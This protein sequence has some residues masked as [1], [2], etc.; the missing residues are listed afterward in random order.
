MML[1]KQRCSICKQETS[2]RFIRL[3]PFAGDKRYSTEAL[4]IC[5]RCEEIVTSMVELL[6][7]TGCES[8]LTVYTERGIL[9]EASV[10]Y[11]TQTQTQEE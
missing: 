6:I 7:L 3:Y 4:R 5:K 2:C 11:G 8:R 1:S 9:T 10:K